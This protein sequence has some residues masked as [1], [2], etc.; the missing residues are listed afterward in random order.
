[1]LKTLLVDEVELMLPEVFQD[2]WWLISHAN[3]VSDPN[4][5]VEVLF[6]HVDINGIQ[7]TSTAHSNL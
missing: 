2:L 3:N 5:L 4:D 1:M 7:S 6:D